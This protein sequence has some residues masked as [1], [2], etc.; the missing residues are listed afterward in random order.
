MPALFISAYDFPLITNKA[1]RTARAINNKKKGQLFSFLFFI[2]NYGGETGKTP[3][4]FA[5]GR[6]MAGRS[7]WSAWWVWARERGSGGRACSGRSFR[8]ARPFGANRGIAARERPRVSARSDGAHRDARAL[9]AAPTPPTTRPDDY[10]D[11]PSLLE[12]TASARSRL[13]V[14]VDKPTVLSEARRWVLR[15]VRRHNKRGK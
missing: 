15:A 13:L 6:Y 11:V 14:H 8:Y 1:P 12:R 10:L 4:A 3:Y 2:K 5:H 9:P 7:Q